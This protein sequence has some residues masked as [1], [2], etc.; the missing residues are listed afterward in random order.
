MLEV[1]LLGPVEVLASGTGVPLAPLERNLLAL[2]ALSPG[3]V[4]ST[5]R[6]ID[7]LWGERPPAAPRSRVQGLVSTLRRKLGDVLITRHPGYLLDL[8][9]GAAD[10]ARCEDLAA[11]AGRAENPAEAA[12]WLRRALGLWRGEP[13]DGISA[14]GVDADRVRL[15]ELRAG[16][17]EDRFDAELALARHKEIV[18][19]LL[20]AVAAHPLRERLAGQ[21][22]TALYRSNR[23][24]DALRAYQALRERLADELGGEP[25]ADLRELHTMILRGEQRPRREPSPATRPA[26]EVSRD[27]PRPAQM[28]A[29]SGHFTGREAELDALTAALPGDGDE[30]RV[31]VVC[32]AG[33]IGK[34]ALVV[35]WAHAVA[36]RF[37]DGQIYV[38]LRGAADPLSPGAALGSVLLALGVAAEQ[39]PVSVD[40]RAALYRTLTHGRRV[41]VVADGASGAGQ[42]LPLVPPTP[43]SVVVAT[44]RNRLAALAAHHAVRTLALDPLGEDAAGHLLRAIVGADRLRGPGAAEIVELCGG[45]PLALR[46]A[47]ATLAARRLQSLPSFAE[48]LRERVDVLSVADDPRTVRG[49]LAETHDELDPAAARLFAQLG[50]LPGATASLALAAAASGTSVLR[51]RRL[52]DELLAANLVVETGPDRYW[53]HEM[54]RRHARRCGRRLP[55]RA[56][57]EERV[58]RWYLAVFD[59]LAREAEPLREWPSVAGHAEWSPFADAA[60]AARFVRAES[61]NLAAVIAWA[62]D[63]DL[64]TAW[65]LV[66]LTHTAG[67]DLD[68]ETA[69]LGLTAARQ[70]DDRR[71]VGEAHAR[72]G[73]VLLGDPA[74]L[75]GAEGHLALAAELLDAG[76]GRLPSAASFALGLV[77]ARQSRQ[78]EA[79]EAVESALRYLDPGRE[80]IA[81]AIA[82]LGYAQV[83]VR[84]GALDRGHERFAQAVILCQAAIGSQGD[85]FGR[86]DR[87]WVYLDQQLAD[88]YLD[89]LD[90]SLDVPRVTP[91]DRAL[92]RALIAVSR[93]LR[94]REAAAGVAIPAQRRRDMVPPR[95]DLDAAET[96]PI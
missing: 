50:L 63:R 3:T 77:R 53:L 69:E 49:A 76:H 72:L 24:A 39:L 6:I 82:L 46:L 79:R 27:E 58:S 71:A 22:M 45:W 90:R 73:L 89:H 30:P 52:L 25:C 5:E 75:D 95:L 33:G 94:V 80:P 32:G 54:V 65:R 12:D 74:R 61:G 78:A 92:S 87:G 85:R 67:A 43:G 17:M 37:P 2:L 9:D 88:E 86:F 57:V 40:E 26:P 19:E 15:A 47:G 8:P 4:L 7:G 14:P 1:V 21:L 44:G 31:L 55:D 56:V 38:E 91:A 36:D 23:Q 68:P 11:R 70:L 60:S 42:I 64:R 48:E 62:A 28:P 93:A 10:L 41:L 16:L 96:Y 59:A 20:T 18:G 35:R 34:T 84:A 83:L 66:S 81:Y 13:L 51:A 29:S